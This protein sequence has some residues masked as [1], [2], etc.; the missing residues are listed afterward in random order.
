MI[1]REIE[2]KSKVPSK[3]FISLM[4]DYFFSMFKIFIL[5]T[6]INLY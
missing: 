3:Y 6:E 4:N 5:F 2:K 1:V